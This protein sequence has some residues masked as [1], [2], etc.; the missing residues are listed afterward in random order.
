MFSVSPTFNVYFASMQGGPQLVHLSPE[1]AVKSIGQF[2]RQLRHAVH[3]A[4]DAVGIGAAIAHSRWRRRRLLILCYHGVS[5]DDEH[6][7]SNLYVS[8]AHLARRVAGLRRA[9]ASVL[10]L[11]EALQRLQHDDLPPQSV[12]VTFDDGAYDFSARAVPILEAASMHATLYLT[13]WYCG[14]PLPVFDTMASYLL[15]KGRGRVLRI[16]E[17]ESTVRIGAATTEPDFQALHQKIRSLAEMGAYTADEKHA[18]LERLATAI[19]VDFASIMERRMLQLMT[20]Q[21]VSLLNQ[22][23][24]AIEL[25][26]HRHRTSRIREVFLHEL[27]E[28]QA[29]ISTFTGDA[30]L[31]RHFCYP[32]GDFIPEYAHWLKD[33]GVESATTCNPGLASGAD[34]PYF[35]PR[36]IDTE[37]MR[38]TTFRAWVSGAA[39]F[40]SRSVLPR[41]LH[42]RHGLD[43]RH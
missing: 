13:T 2:P 20:P 9:N 24:V 37:Q 25:H 14:R 41:K 17:F 18:Y 31:R 42:R 7:W 29:Q 19:G 8:P 26:T 11:D 40:T 34:D 27:K 33:A 36:I 21:E 23:L 4:A 32:S 22:D 38:P 43:A 15:W 3:G 28:N 39:H 6:L 30:R 5:L 1:A 10:P 16:P 12:T 35:L